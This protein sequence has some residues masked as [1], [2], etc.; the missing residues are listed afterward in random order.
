MGTNDGHLP[1]GSAKYNGLSWGGVPGKRTWKP[2]TVARTPFFLPDCGAMTN[3]STPQALYPSRAAAG[4]MLGR[5]LYHRVTPPVLLLGITPT[6]VEIAAAAAQGISAAFDVIVGAH[7]RLDGHGIIGAIAE[8]GDAVIDR[9]FEP[10]FSLLDTLNEAI[11]RARRAV[12]SERLLFRG[13]RQIRALGEQTVIV[14]DGYVTSPWKLLA[15]AET[16]LALGAG[17]VVAAAAVATQT[18]KERVSAHKVD[19]VC[20]TVVLDDAGHLRPFGDPQEPSAERLRSI[21]VARQA[22]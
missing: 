22:A 4:T 1:I 3:A 16:A 2:G 13:Q 19:F 17:R 21:V 9:G 14:I 10:G 7:I 5:Q 15:S 11:D 20:P 12:K 18:A 6:G 8:D